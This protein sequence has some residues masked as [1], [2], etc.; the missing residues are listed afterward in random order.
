MFFAILSAGFS[1]I[2]SKQYRAKKNLFILF[3]FDKVEIS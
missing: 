3:N 1:V 2:K